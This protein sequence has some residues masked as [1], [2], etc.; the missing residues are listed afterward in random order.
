MAFIFSLLEVG[1]SLILA[2]RESDYP[3][4]KSLYSL[5]ARAT[6][7]PQSAAALGVVGMAILAI[8]LWFSARLLGRRIVDLF[9][10][11]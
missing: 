7:G 6:E 4:T 10:P 11:L 9:R 1:C 3:L 8:G 2:F 5:F